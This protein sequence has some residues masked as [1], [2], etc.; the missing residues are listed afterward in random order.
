MV[1]I[2]CELIADLH[3]DENRAQVAA[4]MNAILTGEPYV[5]PEAEWRLSWSAWT[6]G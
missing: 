4:A 5:R 6:A 3:H 2:Y 1:I